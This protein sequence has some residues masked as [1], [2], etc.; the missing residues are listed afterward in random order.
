MNNCDY[1]K[2][3]AVIN[4]QKMWIAWALDKKGNYT[5]KYKFEDSREDDEN[6]HLCQKHAEKWRRGEL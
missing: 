3:T 4:F 1:C 2:K 6:L 5:S